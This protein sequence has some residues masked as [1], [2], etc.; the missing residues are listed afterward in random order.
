MKKHACARSDGGSESR[1]A[2]YS[3]PET[4]T[5]RGFTGLRQVSLKILASVCP[6]STHAYSRRR[7]RIARPPQVGLH[8]S[9]STHDS[10][11]LIQSFACAALVVEQQRKTQSLRTFPF[12]ATVFLLASP[13]WSWL[14][15]ALRLTWNNLYEIRLVVVKVA[16]FAGT[17]ENLLTIARR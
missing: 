4:P 15:M 7:G 9:P 8:L 10:E 13:I 11:R 2:R 1:A 3:C 6:R 5:K 14:P 17:R 12:R 16:L